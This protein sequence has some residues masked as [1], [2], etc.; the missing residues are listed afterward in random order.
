MTEQYEVLE[1]QDKAIIPYVFRVGTGLGEYAT[2]ELAEAAA[3]AKFH[4]IMVAV[5]GS[6]VPY[7]GALIIH[8]YGKNKPMIEDDEMVE[9]EVTA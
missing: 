2:P 5:Y 9:R 3:H 8:R 4:D 1:E 6:N 7:H